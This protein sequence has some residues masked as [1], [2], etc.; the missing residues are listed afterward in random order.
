LE[1]EVTESVFLE[2]GSSRV[3]KSFEQLRG[4]GLTIALDDFGTG[5]AS[6]VHLKQFPIDTIKIDRSIIQT[7]DDPANAAIVHAIIDLGIRLDITTVAEGLETGSLHTPSSAR[8]AVAN[9]PDTAQPD[10]SEASS[11]SDRDDDARPETAKK[12]TNLAPMPRRESRSP[13]HGSNLTNGRLP[14]RSAG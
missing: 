11:R 2:R 8:P 1:L 5:Y 7:L 13:Q 6:L 3:M 4:A 14:M 12:T 10:S 9:E